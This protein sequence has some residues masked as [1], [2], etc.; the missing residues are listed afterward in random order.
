M[1]REILFR[2]MDINGSWHYG[3]LAESAGLQGQVKEGVYISNK[4]GAPCA[5]DIRPET[6]GQFIGKRDKNNTRIFEG[7]RLKYESSTKQ[8]ISFPYTETVDPSWE[9]YEIDEMSIE[10]TVTLI[11]QH[12]S[13]LADLPACKPMNKYMVDESVIIGNVHEVDK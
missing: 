8:M 5:Y 1:K 3:L 11:K 13:Y 6:V 2:G 7:D 12:N 9:I 10:Q 4:V